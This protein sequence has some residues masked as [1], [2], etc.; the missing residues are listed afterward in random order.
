MKPNISVGYYDG[1]CWVS[2]LNPTYELFFEKVENLVE[3]IESN[4]C[5]VLQPTKLSDSVLYSEVVA[6][7]TGSGLDSL[8]YAR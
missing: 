2:F 4:N 1:Q 5:S 6:F 7:L 3:L 8:M